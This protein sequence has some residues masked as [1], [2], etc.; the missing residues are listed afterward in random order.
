MPSLVLDSDNIISSW[1]AE[2]IPVV[3]GGD[4]GKCEALGVMTD[5]LIAGVVYHDYQPAYRTIQMSMASISPMWAR[6][7]I[8]RALLA[9]PFRQLDCFKVYV[10]V[11]LQNTH[12]LKTNRHIGFKQEA[13]LAHQFGPKRHAVMMRMLQPDFAKRYEAENG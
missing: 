4:F 8:I 2:R 11:E 3:A 1:V 7:D 5:K 9:Y 10:A 12:A 6:K 13:T